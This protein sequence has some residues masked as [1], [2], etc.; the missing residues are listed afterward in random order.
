MIRRA[1]NRFVI[2]SSRWNIEI[3]HA[4]ERLPCLLV[5]S[6]WAF[7]ASR[8]TAVEEGYHGTCELFMTG[9]IVL[10]S[11]AW[12]SW[13]LPLFFF[14]QNRWTEYQQQALGD[15]AS[16]VAMFRTWGVAACPAHRQCGVV[17]WISG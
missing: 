15:V 12:H 13:L 5:S 11:C 16:S 10:A 8:G 2:S 4:T 3:T 17:C 14:N 9:D 6:T 7:I 1:K